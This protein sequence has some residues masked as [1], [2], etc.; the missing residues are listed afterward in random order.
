ML[1]VSG[2]PVKS[3]LPL[4]VVS[5]TN[6]ADPQQQ[7]LTAGSGTSRTRE[8]RQVLSECSHLNVDVERDLSLV[9]RSGVVDAAELPERLRAAISDH[10]QLP[11][12]HLHEFTHIIH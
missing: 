5:A 4:V 11:L 3:A 1:P 7:L 2:I 9:E 8:R 12:Q 10:P 6:G